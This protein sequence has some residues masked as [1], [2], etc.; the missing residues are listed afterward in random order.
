V[1]ER[2][3]K[4]P[5]RRHLLISF[6]L[7]LLILLV[8][9]LPPF[10]GKRP[11]PRP[12]VLW[13][14]IVPRAASPRIEEPEAKTEVLEEKEPKE[15][16]KLT[17]TPK[18]EPEKPQPPKAEEPEEPEES[19]ASAGSGAQDLGIKV[20][21]GQEFQYSY[22][23]A[24]ILKKISSNWQRAERSTAGFVAVVYFEIERDGTLSN[25]RVEEG[26]GDRDFDLRAERALLLTRK[27]PPLPSSFE[28]DRLLVHLEFEGR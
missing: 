17:Q 23:L 27:L 18:K 3:A 25:I 13:V 24:M 14:G 15:P 26:S 4:L 10:G 5:L 9:F 2:L 12:S 6:F 19:V 11:R 21:E 28:H 16:E 22:Y 20:M 8:V 1:A 7:H